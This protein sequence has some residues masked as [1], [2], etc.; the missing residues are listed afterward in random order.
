MHKRIFSKNYR[1]GNFNVLFSFCESSSSQSGFITSNGKI[2]FEKNVL[3]MSF[4]DHCV[5]IVL[6]RKTKYSSANSCR[7]R[8]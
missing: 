5:K 4:N 8:K 3:T 7:Y 2:I 1:K 6:F